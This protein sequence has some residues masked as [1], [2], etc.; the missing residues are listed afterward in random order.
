MAHDGI[1]RETLGVVHVL[2]SGKTTEHRLPQEPHQEVAGVLAAPHLREHRPGQLG[3]SKRV[4]QFT[5]RQQASVR[6]DVAAMEF[7]LEAPVEIDPERSFVRSPFRWTM[8]E[9]RIQ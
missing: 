4:V 8:I 7:Q 9:P 1:L 2:V 5:I 3:Q 6:R